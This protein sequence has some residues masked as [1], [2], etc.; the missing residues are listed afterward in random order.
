M[1][2]AVEAEFA[3]RSEGPLT[4]PARPMSTRIRAYFAPPPLET[5]PAA[6]GR[7]T[8]SGARPIRRFAAF[9]DTNVTPHKVP[10]YGIVTISL[11]PIGG[12]PGDA[13]AE[14]MDV[15]ADL[16]DRYS[17]GELRVSARAEPRP[18]ACRARRP[19]GALRRAATAR[20]SRRRMPASSPTSS[21]ARASTIARWRR[22]A[23]S[24][25]RSASP[26]A[27]ATA[28]ARGE[29][30]ELKIKISGCI[31][32]CGHHHVGH[33]GILGLDR[34]GDETYQITLGGSADETG[35]ARRPHRPG[36]LDRRRRRRRRDGRRHLSRPAA[37]PERRLPGR[38]SAASAWLPSRRR[39]TRRRGRRNLSI[40]S[41]QDVSLFGD[42]IAASRLEQR[43]AAHRC[44][45]P[46][47]AWPSTTCFR[48]A[49]RSCRAS[50]RIRPCCSTWSPPIDPAT[51]VIF[52]DTRPAFPGD[53]RLSRR[54]RRPSRPHRCA[55]G[56]RRP[57]RTW[58]RSIP[59]ASSGRAIPTCAATSARSMPLGRAIEALRRLDHRP[60]A[61]PER[62][63]RSP[64]AVRGRGRAHQDQSAGGLGRDRTAGLSR[65]PRPAA[66]PAGRQGY[67]SIG[68]IPCTSRV[69][70][71]GC[72]GRP[73]ARQGQDRV[74][75]PCHAG[76]VRQR[77]L[78]GGA[79]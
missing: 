79:I 46:C 17:Y 34:K 2:E 15:V 62:D 4:L 26:S 39:S 57:R 7:L 55:G 13:T 75:H 63:P 42:Q 66:P 64:A 61:V 16:A 25:S 52:V 41:V 48:A 76:K 5:R 74:R 12:I 9:V 19:A 31:N 11:K 70:R 59:R 71:R 49:S 28:R 43:F 1:R 35:L 40:M 30:G 67:P 78:T 24:R 54:P 45:A 27:S 20:A 23:R 65:P 44:A 69:P 73:L 53:A 6:L 32:A 56:H 14:Q 47:C 33:I 22:R 68:C 36:L 77:H 29:I 21:P 72:A 8:A 51:P 3:K 38:L 18:A 50:A 37:T 60:Q 58:R 10:G